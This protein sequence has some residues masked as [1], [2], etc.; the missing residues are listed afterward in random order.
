MGTRARE[1][2]PVTLLSGFLV[3][4]AF[5]FTISLAALRNSRAR[6]RQRSY[7]TFS[8]WSMG[9]VLLSWSTTLER[10][11]ASSHS[12]MKLS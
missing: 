9:C 10:E 3:R 7:S 2:L 8:R 6:E 4:Y 5:L 12:W 11:L 1:P